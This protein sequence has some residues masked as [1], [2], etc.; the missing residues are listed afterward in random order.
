MKTNFRVVAL[1]V[2]LMSLVLCGGREEETANADEIPT[3]VAD[4]DANLGQAGPIPLVPSA[5]TAAPDQK[6]TDDKPAV[7][8]AAPATTD[9]NADPVTPEALK[10]SPALTDVIKLAQAGVGEQ[11]LM[12]YIRNSTNIFNI[13]PDEILY[14]HDL[15]VPSELITAIIQQD[16]TP[17]ALA[18]KHAAGAAQPLPPGVALNAP[19]TN[20]FTP[21][22]ASLPAGGPAGFWPGEPPVDLTAVSTNAVP[23]D[24]NAIPPVVYTVPEVVQQPVNVSYFYNE[25]APYGAWVDVA[26]Y[27]Y[28]W[29]PTVAVWNSGWRPYADCGRWLWTDCGWYWYSGYSWGWAPFHYGRW[30]CAGGVGW[31]WV[32]GSAWAPAWVNWRVTPSYCGWAPLAPVHHGLHVVGHSDY[33]FVAKAHLGGARLRDSLVSPTHA[34]RL[35]NDSTAADQGPDFA[36]LPAGAR[37]SM[38]PV[39]VRRTTGAGNNSSRREQLDTQRATLTIAHPPTPAPT[40]VRPT[41]TTRPTSLVG[42]QASLTTGSLS[43]TASASTGAQQPT[44]STA[45]AANAS[46]RVVAPIIM[47][48]NGR[49]GPAMISGDPRNSVPNPASLEFH[50][51]PANNNSQARRTPLAGGRAAPAGV[52]RPSQ[53]V[54]INSA[55][56]P[57]IGQRSAA[58][59]SR[60]VPIRTVSQP[61][62]QRLPAAM[63][64]PVSVAPAPAVRAA[65]PGPTVSASPAARVATPATSSGRSAPAQVSGGSRSARSSGNDGGQRGQR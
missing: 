14:L 58:S 49:S 48:G 56:A 16:A 53:T 21:R 50:N 34:T 29:R 44:A 8:N 7:T 52:E 17:E 38:R 12:T 33:V 45:P 25:L 19:A 40:V 41:T 35:A 39:A 6:A 47:R 27:G 54:A 62:V 43:P 57:P 51:P 2:G 10:L 37:D 65:P 20:V 55:T 30:A 9:G 32:P 1:G 61:S 46:S 18:R 31:V 4:A 26:G 42:Q 28:C 36:S 13:G 64:P 3:L 60:S 15:G 59:A 22:I 23:G 24:T 63:P 11:V 5:T